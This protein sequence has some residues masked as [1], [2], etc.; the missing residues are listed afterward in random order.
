MVLIFEELSGLTIAATEYAVNF[1]ELGFDSLFLT[2]VA[3]AVQSEFDVKVTFRQLL[4][5][6]GS[7]G[8]LADFIDDKLPAE[9]VAEQAP[10]RRTRC[11]SPDG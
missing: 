6:Q 10:R 2:Q 3:Q 5:D 8:S 7:L 1:L 9:A 11:R 4:G